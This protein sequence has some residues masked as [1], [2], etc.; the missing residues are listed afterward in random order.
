MFQPD[1]TRGD[2]I[3]SEELLQSVRDKEKTIV[4]AISGSAY[5]NEK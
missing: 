1:L 3:A 2:T 5:N 4:V